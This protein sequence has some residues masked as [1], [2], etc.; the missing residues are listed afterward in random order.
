MK[1]T[2]IREVQAADRQLMISELIEMFHMRYGTMN[3]ILEE[4]LQMLK[5]ILSY[6]FDLYMMHVAKVSDHSYKIVNRNNQFKGMRYRPL[7]ELRAA[8][9]GIVPQYGQQ[10]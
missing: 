7:Q 10:W 8:R 6:K 1:V 4:D 2:S 5:V 9:S 3:R